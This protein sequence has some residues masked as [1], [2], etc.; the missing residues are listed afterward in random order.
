MATIRLKLTGTQKAQIRAATGREVN[1]LEL[2]FQSG[3]E[4]EADPSG[5]AALK[6]PAE[7]HQGTAPEPPRRPASGAG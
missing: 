1:W 3:P 7:P 2:R 4:L 6:P 5:A